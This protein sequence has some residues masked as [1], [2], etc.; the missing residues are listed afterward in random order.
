[1]LF[2][3]CFRGDLLER[4][5]HQSI[6]RLPLCSLAAIL[7]MSWVASWFPCLAVAFMPPKKAAEP[8]KAAPK[9]AKSK[10]KAK[11]AP[12]EDPADVKKMQSNLTTQGKANLKRLQ[13][14]KE[15][16]LS[17]PE[18]GRGP[19]VK[20]GIFPGIYKFGQIIAPRADDDACI[21]ASRQ[22]QAKHGLKSLSRTK[23]RRKARQGPWPGS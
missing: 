5:S 7:F 11:A 13:E 16:K 4:Y 9:A 19:G 3:A 15:G 18:R 23:P 21:M 1:M 22:R 6:S 14:Y 20:G 17:F 8:K 10:A 2:Q 12:A